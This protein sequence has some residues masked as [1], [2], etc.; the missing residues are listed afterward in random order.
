LS[1]TLQYDNRDRVRPY[2]PN[3]PYCGYMT[4]CFNDGML[5]PGRN[6]EPS[7]WHRECAARFMKDN[8]KIYDDP[9]LETN[10]CVERFQKYFLELIK[11][12]NLAEAK[13]TYKQTK[14]TV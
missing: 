11:A 8:R 5:L 1:S 6:L 13:Y 3:C 12:V 10:W 2:D 9:E 4:D 14:L 7:A